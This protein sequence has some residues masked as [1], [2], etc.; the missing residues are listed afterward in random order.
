MSRLLASVLLLAGAQAL[1]AN[2][3]AFVSQNVPALMTPGQ[4]YSVSVTMQNTG[5][6]SWS[7]GSGYKLGTQNPQDNTLWTG[8]T[9]VALPG[10]V[11]PGQNVTFTFNV[12]APSTPGM[13][14]FQWKM[15]QE[16]VEWFGA[17]SANVLVAVGDVD[18]AQFVSQTTPPMMYASQAYAASVTMKN[19]GG[20]TWTPGSY[21]LRSQNPQDNTNWGLNRVEL[22][23]AVAPGQNGTFSFNISYPVEG[24]VNFQWRMAQDGA[25]FGD[26]SP[27][28]AIGVTGINNAQFISQNVP[29]AMAP[30]Q[31]YPVSV[32]MRN[33]GTSTWST[34]HGFKLGTQNPQDNT[35]WTGATR[36]AL[37]QSVAPGQDVT[38]AFNVTAPSTPGLHNFQWRMVREGY[39][40]FGQQSANAVVAVGAVS[41]AQFVSQSAPTSMQASQSYPVSVTLKNSG[42]TTW[43]PGTHYLRSQNPQDNS[44]W[45]LNRVDLP[46]QVPPGQNVTLNFSIAYP[47]T[48]TVNF[49][50]QMAE[51][52]TSFGELTPN[53]AIG[54][55]GTNNAAFVSQSV[56][57]TMNAGQ[58]YPVSVT[59]QNTGTNTWSAANNFRLGTQNPQDNTLW[60][61]ATRVL[62]PAGVNVAPGANATFSFSVSAPSAPGTYNFQWKMLRELVEWFGPLTPNVAVNVQ[63]AV[64]EAKL[65]FIH[66]DHLNTPRL[67]TNDQHQAVWRWDQ[68]EPF[69]VNVADENPSGLGTF[70]LPL[71][72]PGQYFDK[73]TNLHYN[74]FRDYD[75]SLGRYVESDPIGL[76]GGLN[77]Y[78]YADEDPIGSTDQ[79]GLRGRRGKPPVQPSKGNTGLIDALA[80]ALPQPPN[81]NFGDPIPGPPREPKPFRCFE[82]CGS[83]LQCVA[84]PPGAYPSPK[85][86]CY[87][88]CTPGPTIGPY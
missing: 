12:T 35:V 4:T 82:V 44:N 65:H 3:A 83:A 29:T 70:D 38:F 42:G 40:W 61:G 72:L 55:T 34:A 7:S 22:A 14:N 60:T 66:V 84:P 26:S 6:T 78:T 27:N 17:Q 18:H 57:S 19:T 37:P 76:R 28:V 11:A 69:G 59:L 86:N 41:Y 15:L 21:Y 77:T 43:N 49:R 71:R 8:S 51:G 58:T 36:V 20:T 74:Y 5:T 56:P 81:F 63:P 16:L 9:R 79:Y 45:G 1:A 52:T 53:L 33:V 47:V 85:P 48:S 64:Q 68:Q 2:N 32:T 62:L 88:T 25:S 67:V 30:G 24:S 46:A 75:A 23:G 54:V 80:D 31:T 39:E 87:V 13:Y 50:W 10:S 73:E